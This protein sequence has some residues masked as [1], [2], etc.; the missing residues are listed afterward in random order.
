MAEASHRTFPRTEGT[1]TV[2]GPLGRI[3]VARD[4]HG[5]PHIFTTTE[6]D[7]AF[8]HGYV[9]AQDRLFQM[10]G[11]RRV[12]GGRLAEIG[13]QRLLGSD[14][15]MRRMGLRRAAERDLPAL[16]PEVR[17]FIEAYALGVNAGVHDLPALP[18]E[19]ALLRIGFEPWSV[20]DS[21]LVGR[22]LLVGFAGNWNTELVREGLAAA[23]GPDLAAAVDSIHPPH[24][25]VTGREYAP[26]QAERVLKA[27]R[28]TLSVGLPSG[29][30]SN[31]WAVSGARTHSGRPLLGGDPHV[32]VSLPG[33]FH[34]AHVQGGDLNVIGAGI[35]GI[36]GVLMGHN[37][38]LAWSITAGMADVAD[39]YI[40][41]FD[42]TEPRR[43]RTPEGWTTAEEHIETIMVRDGEPHVERVLVTR[44]GS[45]IGPALAGE[46]RDVALRSTALEPGDLLTP[47]MALWRARSIA[48]ADRALDG[49]PGTTFN[50][51]MADV[52]GRIGYRMAGGV[53]QHEAGEGLLP[54][55]GATSPGPPP[56]WLPAAL[57]KLLDPPD[58]IVVS[59]NNAP[60][61][62]LELGEE[63][64]DPQRAERIRALVEG[65]PKHD[66]ASFA[67]IQVD[68][69]SRLLERFRDVLLARGA[70]EG[71]YAR[72]LEGW[73]GVLAPESAAAALVN[74]TWRDLARFLAQR[75]AGPLWTSILGGGAEGTGL[76]SAFSYRSQGAIV[77]S[78]ER[79]TGPWFDGPEDRDRQ[80][81]G[82]AT[83]AAGTLRAHCGGG[84]ERW[85]LGALHR[86]KLAHALDGVPAVG[87]RF[88]RGEHPYGGDMNTVNQAMSGAWRRESRVAVAP[89]F[90]Q[91]LDLADWDASVFMLPT[92]NSGIP[93]HPRYDDCIGEYLAGGYRPLVFSRAAVEAAAEATLTI[94]PRSGDEAHR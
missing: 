54:Q 10:E 33:L 72:L 65:A 52:D 26:I 3:E 74:E 41:T 84:P 35:A 44:H 30:A 39:C 24:G 89:G 16:A 25:T 43:Y 82:A 37:E 78:A 42:P 68:R 70:V 13:G 48:E 51:V 5:I 71:E 45:V 79:A 85:T 91:V 56:T 28:A 21:L 88:S 87:A 34:A 55:Q 77:A 57:P 61:S 46:R 7:A 81:R 22:L 11:A 6:H 32:D 15:F 38:R 4:R 27:Y 59:S 31:A 53:P 94:E 66:V 67:A 1:T 2:A 92:G 75:L 64:C 73:D 93:G 60:G 62:A 58:G 36:P 90:R 14:R 63:W 9:H 20:T 8:G 69:R 86:L 40:E 80:L 19:F 47:F 17:A 50:F 12:A 49:W 76:N 23:L 29:L 18:P 83:R